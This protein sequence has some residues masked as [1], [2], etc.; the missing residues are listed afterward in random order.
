MQAPVLP[1][2]PVP[3]IRFSFDRAAI[4]QALEG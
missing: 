1:P 4:M 2:V 3:P